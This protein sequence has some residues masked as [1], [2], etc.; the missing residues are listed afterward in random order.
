MVVNPYFQSNFFSSNEQSLL[1]SLVTESIQQKGIDV[2]YVPRQIVNYDEL[3]GADDSSRYNSTYTVEM[4]VLSTQGFSGDKD[5]WSQFGNQIRDEVKFSVAI[6]RFRDAV[7]IPANIPRPDE[8]DLIYFP[9]N[10]KCFQVKF[11]N[12][13]ETFYQL[14][15]LYM[16]EL[17]CEL[18]EYSGE[19]FSTGVAEIDDINQNSLNVL[20]WATLDANNNPLFNANGDVVTVPGYHIEGVDPSAENE[21]LPEVANNFVLPNFNPYRGQD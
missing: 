19:K 10:K 1:R 5:F 11:V 6:E 8:G 17:T 15:D 12:S 20:D 9:L 18:F 21:Y 7:G 4:Y 3:F 13:K 2:K 16:Y 14:G